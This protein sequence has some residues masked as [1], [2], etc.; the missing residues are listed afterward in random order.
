MQQAVLLLAVMAA[1]ADAPST[2]LETSS[3]VPVDQ[4]ACL[5][6]SVKEL[7]MS[8]KR[9]GT[10]R[11]WNIASKF[12]HPTV[13]KDGT[14]MVRFEKGDKVSTIVVT[15]TWA[16]GVKD[17]DVQPELEQRVASMARK[18][19]QLCGVNQP[20]VACKLTP[21]GGAPVVCKPAP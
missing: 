13:A 16:G 14:L 6:H 10:D 9:Q 5:D 2:R 18:M 12:L 20:D 8:A 17:K 1:G 15:A 7:G 21:A 11:V 3:T 4:D 19:S